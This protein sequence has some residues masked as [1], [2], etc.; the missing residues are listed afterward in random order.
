MLRHSDAHQAALDA[1]I[2]HLVRWR[3]GC[4]CGERLASRVR[5]G[6][7]PRRR[8]ETP[9]PSVHSCPRLEE[10]PEGAKTRSG[11]CSVH[12]RS[13][14]G[15][16]SG[17]RPIAQNNG[18][19]AEDRRYEASPAQAVLFNG[20]P[21]ALICTTIPSKQTVRFV[22][23]RFGL[24]PRPPKSGSRNHGFRNIG[25]NR[26]RLPL[27]A[28]CR[29]ASLPLLATTTCKLSFRNNSANESR[30]AYKH[31]LGPKVQPR[32]SHE[33]GVSRGPME[34]VAD[35]RRR[36]CHPSD[37]ASQARRPESYPNHG[38]ARQARD[39]NHHGDDAESA[40]PAD[41]RTRSGGGG[42]PPQGTSRR[43]NRARFRS[44]AP[45]AGM[46]VAHACPLQAAKSLRPSSRKPSAHK[47][48]GCAPLLSLCK[49]CACAEGDGQSA[50]GCLVGLSDPAGFNTCCS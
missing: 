15:A 25:D 9:A 27:L 47:D 7:P 36:R 44:K 2:Q 13:T 35:G 24:T 49:R 37:R 21:N 40:R 18:A 30:P 12:E 31:S 33:R 17:D 50:I 19:L 14:R 34:G 29:G 38:I 43:I 10:R 45:E 23:G 1:G 48:G 26:G 6:Q 32:R 39:A 42:R 16:A 41:P 20:R 22:R 28:A 46:A 4:A 3:G 8:D 11:V 5:V